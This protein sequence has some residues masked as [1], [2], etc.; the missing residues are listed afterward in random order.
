VTI[1]A[2][3]R[4]VAE[5]FG[6]QPSALKQKTNARNIAFPRQVAMH[7]A[8]DLTGASL[9]ELGRVFGGKHHTTVLHSI[10]KIEGLRQDNP[11]LDKT[12]HSLTDTI[13]GA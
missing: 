2:V 9:P 10:E 8:R 13:Q 1:D 4:A 11:D 7:I 3:I 6:L 5:H 12:I